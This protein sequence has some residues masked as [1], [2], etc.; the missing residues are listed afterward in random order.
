MRPARL[1]LAL[2]LVAS[3]DAPTRPRP[4]PDAS[5]IGSL[6]GATG[7]LQCSDLPYESNTVTIGRE[8]GWIS[9]GPHALYVPPGALAEPTAIT[10]T[11]PTGDAVNRVHFE[12]EGLQFQKPAALTMSYANCSLLGRL[13]PKRI[14]YTSSALDIISYLLSFDNLWT[15]RVTGRLEHFSDY[16]I[17]W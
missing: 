8:G 12:P 2:L 15:R 11:Q 14:A 1:L 9:A 17:A 7:L 3:C 4:E 5:L 10:M 16:A 6:L 13:A